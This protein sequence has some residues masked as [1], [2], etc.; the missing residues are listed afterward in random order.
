MT[1]ITG[2]LVGLFLQTIAKELQ[3]T[4]RYAMGLAAINLAEA[5]I[6]NAL[7]ASLHTGWNEWTTVVVNGQTRRFRDSFDYLSLD[8]DSQSR[9]IKVYVQSESGIADIIIAEATISLSNNISVT[10]Q[11]GIEVET[12]TQRFWVNAILGRDELEFEG[13]QSFLDS[14]SSADFDPVANP[15]YTILDY[16]NDLRDAAP[17]TILGHDFVNGNASIASLAVTIGAI[18]IG[19]ADV[20]GSLATGAPQGSS[21]NSMVGPQGSLYNEDSVYG[22]NIGGNDR[23]DEAFVSYEFYAELPIPETPNIIGADTND[24]G[25]TIGSAGTSSA[26]EFSDFSVSNNSTKTI[27]G[28]VDIVVLDDVG[29]D[30]TL[31]VNGTVRFV[32]ADQIN[33]GGEVEIANEGSMEVFVGGD[34]DIGGNGIVNLNKPADLVIYS[35]SNAPEASDI[36]IRG[37]TVFSG[38]IYAPNSEIEVRGGA[39]VF[40]SLVGYEIEFKGNVA[41]HYDEELAGTSNSWT[42]ESAQIVGW[43]ELYQPIDMDAVMD[44][45]YTWD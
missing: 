35:T 11:V 3:H 12:N 39:E 34:V 28:D 32:V 41:F 27:N 22:T 43:R 10:R 21:I 1:L 4:H 25:D 40:G 19:N 44:N 2:T 15:G 33:I 9:S 7:H 14:F 16:Y 26:Y 36:R 37:N 18:E 23:I 13:N 6:E 30:G 31:V 42:E 45:G 17:S 5:G 8:T 29:I 38:A 20:Y 24:P